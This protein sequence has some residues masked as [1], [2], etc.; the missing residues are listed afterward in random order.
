MT[1]THFSLTAAA[2]VILSSTLLFAQSAPTDAAPA[3]PSPYQGVSVP[4][5]NDAIVTS[6]EAPATP[7]AVTQPA[8]APVPAPP[9]SQQSGRW[10]HRN[11]PATVRGRIHAAQ[12]SRPE[13]P[14]G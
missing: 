2:T 1:K 6:E 13:Y 10:H 4:P 12:P 5:A 8:P 3:K 9:A 7:P 14:R 11:T